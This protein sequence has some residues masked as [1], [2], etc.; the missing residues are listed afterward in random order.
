MSDFINTEIDRVLDSDHH[1]P[2]QVLGLHFITEKPKAVL[3]RTFQPHAESVKIITGNTKS[4]LYKM[5]QEGLFEIVLHENQEPFSYQLEAT[6]FNG[7]SHVFDDPYRFLPQFSDMDMYL[8]NSG[9]HYQLY[10]KMGAHPA[11]IY[12]VKG[13]VF[14]EW[15]PSARRVSVLGEFNTWDGR[16]HQMRSLDQSGIWEF[17]ISG[18]R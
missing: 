9:T 6:Y 2:F 18:V 1:D 15:A 14:R 4:Y 16:V 13:T 3:V 12:D 11:T 17:F 5:R 8:F 10:E 7:T